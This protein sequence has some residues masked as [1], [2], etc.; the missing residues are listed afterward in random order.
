M[1]Y[2]RASI[3]RIDTVLA[4][5]FVAIL[6]PSVTPA[7]NL[8]PQTP[9]IV[10]IY[11]DDLGYGDVGAYNPG[12]L[13]PTPHMDSL[14]AEGMMFT[15]AHS[16]SGVCTPSRYSLLTGRYSW[17]LAADGILAKGVV[18]DYSTPVI[19]EHETTLGDVLRGKGYHTACFGKW[20]LGMQHFD[21]NGVPFTGTKTAIN[22]PAKID[23]TRVEQTVVDRGF[24]YFFG[25]PNTINIAPFCWMENDTILFRGAPAASNSAWEVKGSKLW[26]PDFEQIDASPVMISNAVSYIASR[27]SNAEPYFAFVS[28]FSPHKPWV[29]TPAFDGSVGYTY[30]DFVHLTDDWIGQVVDAVD[31]SGTAS[32]TVV[33]LT[34]DNG[35][36]TS[37]FTSGRTFGHD[38]NGPLKGVK[39]DSWEGG[40]RVPFIVR[41]PGLV[42]TNSISNELVWQGDIFATLADHLGTNLA[43]SV[44]PDAE[45]F[46]PVLRGTSMPTN[47]RESIVIAS[48]DN[49]LSLCTVD[50][51]KLIDGTGGGG[52]STSYDADNANI[53]GAHGTIGVS[54]RQLFD[55]NADLGERT[56]LVAALPARESE[57]LGLLNEHRA[58]VSV[59][60]VLLDHWAFDESG[61]TVATNST[62]GTNGTLT[63][64]VSVNQGGRVAGAYAFDGSASGIVTAVGYKG[65]VGATPRT[66]CLWL[67]TTAANTGNGLVSWGQQATSK[68]WELILDAGRV[69][70]NVNGGNVIGSTSL[71]DGEW[72]HVAAS[73]EDTDGNP[74][75]GDVTLYIDGET[76]T[77]G[78]RQ[79]IAVGTAAALDVAIGVDRFRA[80][81]Y[82]GKMD[83]VAIWRG[84]LTAGE[85]R[86]LH[87]LA[88]APALEYDVSEA[89]SLI[90]AYTNGPGTQVTI[91]GLGWSYATGL[92]ARVDGQLVT[93]GGRYALV[94]DA[95]AGSGM[96][97][98]DAVPDQP[99]T[100]VHV[101]W[102]QVSRNDTG[103]AF[104]SGTGIADGELICRERAADSETG[105]Q[106][107]AFVKF[108]ISHLTTQQV[109]VATFR[110]TL[111]LDYSARLNTVSGNN[112]LV[113]MG[114]L[115]DAY[116][117]DNVAG[118]YPLAAWVGSTNLAAGLGMPPEHA[119]VFNVLAVAPPKSIVCDVT[120]EVRGWV[121]GI[122]TNNGFAVY[123]TTDANQ[124]AGF[125]DPR[126][127]IA[128][129]PSLADH[130]P[131]D[132]TSGMTAT[133]VT[134]GTDG[135]AG[136]G[137]TPAQPGKV[138]LA[139]TLDGSTNA[140]VIMTGHK[141][142]LGNM[143]RTICAWVK[144]TGT[145]G[146]VS[147]GRDTAS[148]AWDFEIDANDTVGSIRCN[149]STAF[150]RD[151]VD[152]RDRGWQHVATTFTRGG[153]VHTELY[154][155]GVRVNKL[156]GG[157]ELY[158]PVTTVASL[159][160]AIGVDRQ[161]LEFLEG[162][163][164]DV[165]IWG[166]AL[167]PGEILALY[168]CASEPTLNY[169]ASAVQ[170]LFEAY[171]AGPGSGVVID[172]TTW[173][174]AIGLIGDRDGQLTSAGGR[175]EL[176]LD[177]AAGTG[178]AG[179]SEVG[180][181]LI[182]R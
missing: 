117:W 88:V 92:N 119:L 59:P 16:A 145:G 136:A 9:N 58:L 168:N 120:H 45:S 89:W 114:A 139:Y 12:S 110:A 99:P 108:D 76:E 144:P 130:W 147:W 180:S 135:A 138:G 148:D 3:C 171:A 35:P 26:D 155:N 142:I 22:D 19:Q 134:G 55:L 67:N 15:R 154:V 157:S 64:G 85:I 47:R 51:W 116:R 174:H 167:T 173:A 112:L 95:A 2:E 6:V 166:N 54:P 4:C 46:L 8:T 122:R 161:R 126:L 104:F 111:E 152:L 41:W 118:Q 36:E 32:N 38:S 7:Q 125:S 127:L 81:H 159:D 150:V 97:A 162:S 86:S 179:Q 123:G 37:A 18:W 17:R 57:L 30:G 68:A 39:R 20:H 31:A 80:N 60:T 177:A 176:I 132:E 87:E 61:G 56:N 90:D 131:L 82:S 11:A 143:P 77:P 28:L 100:I 140:S 42:E 170:A 53:A 163:V 103:S 52:N 69:R 40:T 71:A 94:V 172:E 34:S 10:I 107:V 96:W 33:I 23:M 50:G 29:V 70:F 106:G 175:Y 109:N 101:A 84:G 49:Q 146:L 63:G 13:V 158:R 153:H 102:D 74:T 169:D 48:I 27:A 128:Y 149:V 72:H 182:V 43:A 156:E 105:L 165:A 113:A 181:V 65:I 21:R 44:A 133:N 83:D 78:S 93:A 178:L 73:F 164:D 141:G 137:V 124:G 98:D 91:G 62:G 24:D 129:H 5:V 25:M 121:N 1:S 75:T 66:V 14:R 115:P 151:T 79:S 160:V